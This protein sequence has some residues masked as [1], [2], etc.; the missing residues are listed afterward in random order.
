M[1]EFRSKEN[2][3]DFFHLI[4]LGQG[5][6]Q[7]NWASQIVR[8]NGPVSFGSES[9]SGPYLIGLPWLGREKM[10]ATIPHTILF[11]SPVY[12]SPEHSGAKHPNSENPRAA[13]AA[14]NRPLR[15]APQPWLPPAW[16]PSPRPSTIAS[17]GN[18]LTRICA[19]PLA[20]TS[21]QSPSGRWVDSERLASVDS[22][23]Q[24]S[25]SDVILLI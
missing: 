7:P 8:S 5:Y 21:S 15:P 20:S 13:N 14:A 12:S 9:Y 24:G 23:V 4:T 11:R 3:L 6:L 10:P 17:S 16:S 1:V 18:P 22:R 19:L 2:L 25:C